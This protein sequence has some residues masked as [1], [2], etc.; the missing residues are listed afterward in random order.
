MLSATLKC[1]NIIKKKKVD[2]NIREK[3]QAHYNALLSVMDF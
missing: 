3:L 1:Y 2:S